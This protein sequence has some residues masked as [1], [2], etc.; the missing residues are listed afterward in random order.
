M[1]V[2]YSKDSKF[3]PEFAHLGDAGFD[4]KAY[5][6]G[7]LHPGDLELFNTGLRMELP[8]T[9][10]MLVL[11]RSGLACKHGITVINSPGLVDSSYRGEIKVGLINLGKESYVVNEEERIAQ[12]MIIPIERISFVPKAYLSSTDRGAGGF[13]STGR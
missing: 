9:H 12:G 1:K 10:C 4:L 3:V 6:G 13:G 5:K 11:P 8:E 7:T 2:F